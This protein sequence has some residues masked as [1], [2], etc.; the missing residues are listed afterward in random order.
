MALRDSSHRKTHWK[1]GWML[2]LISQEFKQSSESL[3]I[4]A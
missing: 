4:E 3:N 2:L 1:E